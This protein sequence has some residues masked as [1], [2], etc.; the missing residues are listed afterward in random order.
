MKTVTGIRGR[1]MPRLQTAAATRRGGELDLAM[2][3]VARDAMLRPSEIP[4]VTWQDVSYRSDGSAQLAVPGDDVHRR[5]LSP[6]TARALAQLLPPDAAPTDRVFR[7][8]TSQINRRVRALC[9]AAGMVGEYAASSPRIGQ[10]EDSAEAGWTVEDI[11]A[12][13]RWK[14][15]DAAWSYVQRSRHYLR[16]RSL[17]LSHGR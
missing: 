11:A 1:D 12:Y 5:P 4:R 13:G 10:A 15:L 2:V 3:A 9:R 17:R 6:E 7:L 8:T 16:L 14:T